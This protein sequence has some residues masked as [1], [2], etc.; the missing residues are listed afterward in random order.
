MINHNVQLMF[1]DKVT[2]YRKTIYEITPF[3]E[4]NISQ[5][6]FKSAK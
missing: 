2:L 5:P 4:P 3:G 6:S 1:D